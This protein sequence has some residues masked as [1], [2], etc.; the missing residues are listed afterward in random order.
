MKDN[1]TKIRSF[2]IKLLLFICLFFMIGCGV[3]ENF[4]YLSKGDHAEF[5]WGHVSAGLDGVDKVGL[6]KVT[7]GSPYLLWCYFVFDKREHLEGTVLISKV[8]IINARTNELLVERENLMEK[9]IIKS[10]NSVFTG[11]GGDPPYSNKSVL[12]PNMHHVGFNI[13]DV[14]RFKD[15]KSE[16]DDLILQIKFIIKE[17]G[18]ENEYSAEILLE[19]R[20]YKEFSSIFE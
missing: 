5:P 13:F 16:Y 2:K 17:G 14:L 19:K 1:N 9:P 6:F 7:R 8:K 4:D 11:A 20:Y 12:V 15:Q 3:Q 10:Y 18:N